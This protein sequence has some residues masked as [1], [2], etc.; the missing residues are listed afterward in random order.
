MSS[1]ENTKVD[2][3]NNLY[4]VLLLEPAPGKLINNYLS[5]SFSKANRSFIMNSSA[6][7]WHEESSVNA[8]KSSL[9]SSSVW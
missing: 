5:P 7:G 1:F 3:D 2:F 9:E 8:A 4:K 6:W